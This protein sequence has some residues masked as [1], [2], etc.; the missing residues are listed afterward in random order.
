MKVQGI[1]ITT[2]QI[3]A[4]LAVMT[5]K[6]FTKNDVLAALCKAGVPY[7]VPNGSR[8]PTIV[9]ERAADSLLQRERRAGR[10]KAV[11]NR[12]WTAVSTA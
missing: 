3:S 9:G 5:K 11:T 7:S 8:H 1:E 10:I 12:T 2:E 6:V 4:G